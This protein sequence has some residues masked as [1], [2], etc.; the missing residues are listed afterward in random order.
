MLCEK[1]KEYMQKIQDLIL[2]TG[3]ISN[4]FAWLISF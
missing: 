2:L 4:C 1:I 3:M